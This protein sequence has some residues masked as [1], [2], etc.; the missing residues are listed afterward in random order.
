MEKK[1]VKKIVVNAFLNFLIKIIFLLTKIICSY[2]EFI[3]KYK[4]LKIFILKL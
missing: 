4:I 3:Y 2:I 1:E